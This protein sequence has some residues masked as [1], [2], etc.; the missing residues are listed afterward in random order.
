MAN[1][2]ENVCKVV[3]LIIVSNILTIMLYQKL[4]APQ[5]DDSSL[6][7][8]FKKLIPA[9]IIKFSDSVNEN[10]MNVADKS[11][12]SVYLSVENAA[13]DNININKNSVFS[14]TATLSELKTQAKSKSDT[15]RMSK[16]EEILGLIDKISFSLKS[17]I[18]SSKLSE[19]TIDWKKVAKGELHILV[20]LKN[21]LEYF[22]REYQLE[23]SIEKQLISGFKC[24]KQLAADQDNILKLVKMDICSEIE[25]YKLAQ[26]N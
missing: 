26:V 18:S 10:T 1:S 19:K 11:E 7:F 16:K 8:K 2:L 24:S 17:L 20:K 4:S 5:G 23:E 3:L 13:A 12:N 15:I 21:Y 14:E 25:W 9:E 22:L 6:Y